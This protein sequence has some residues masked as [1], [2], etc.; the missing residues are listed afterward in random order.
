[1]KR[2][3]LKISF[4]YF[5]SILSIGKL[6]AQSVP[7]SSSVR[8][9]VNQITANFYKAIGQQSRLYDGHEYLPYDPH[10][11]NNA[12]FPYDAKSWLIGEVNYDGTLYKG[13][14]MMYDVYKDIVVALL[15][16]K[17]SMFTLLSERVSEFS[18]GNHYFIRLTANQLINNKADMSPGF[19]NELY[20]GTTEVLAKRKKT[21]Q[22]SSNAV[23]APETSFIST[24][25]YYIKKGG[26]YYKVSG[27]GSVLKVLKDKKSAIQ[28]YFKQNHIKFRDNP[29][30][31]MAKMAYYYDH[32]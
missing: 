6:F 12:L 15:Y 19:Y 21:F 23:A 32:N 31:A 13:V 5:L 26:T 7:D 2:V 8:A 9:E 22:N 11:K 3:I 18:L 10:I 27:Q 17:F 25:D 20:G 28:Q 1:M 4:L 16:N 14:P 24:D 30:D 29:E